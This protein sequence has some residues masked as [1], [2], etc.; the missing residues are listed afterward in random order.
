MRGLDQAKQQNEMYANNFNADS[1]YGASTNKDKGDYV[2]YGQQTGMFR[3][4]ET[5]QETM[6]RFAYGQSGGY[7]QEGGYTE[8]DEVDMTEEELAEFIANGGEVE[9]L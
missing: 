5:G 9:Y 4:N 8:G 7:M 1:L 6:G 3:P 2:A